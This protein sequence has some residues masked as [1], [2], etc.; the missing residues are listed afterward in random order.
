MAA[1]CGLVSAFL[2]VTVEPP[3]AKEV[4]K[5]DCVGIEPRGAGVL[6]KFN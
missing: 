6:V 5:E 2:P 4:S 3:V 1:R